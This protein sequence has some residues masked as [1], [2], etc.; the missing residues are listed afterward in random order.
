M[1]RQESLPRHSARSFGAWPGARHRGYLSAVDLKALQ[2]A[3]RCASR[4]ARAIRVTAST[5]AAAM[6]AAADTMGDLVEIINQLWG[7]PTPGGRLFPAPLRR[8]VVAAPSKLQRPA[9]DRIKAD[10]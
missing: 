5:A 1:R 3:F 6:P 2:G 4:A 10:L 9:A 8:E 7:V